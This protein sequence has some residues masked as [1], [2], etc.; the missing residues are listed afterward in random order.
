M[1]K[2]DIKLKA[3]PCCG[4]KAELQKQSHREYPPSFSVVCT[5]CKLSTANYKN[6]PKAVNAWNIRYVNTELLEAGQDGAQY[7]DNPTIK[8]AT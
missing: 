7:A 5:S 3:C 4:G 8:G 6:I 2:S 1:F